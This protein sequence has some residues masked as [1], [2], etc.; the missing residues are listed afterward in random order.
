[1]DV[2]SLLLSEHSEAARRVR[3]ARQ[4]MHAGLEPDPTHVRPLILESWRR[5]RTAGVDPLW[6]SKNAST[7]LPESVLSATGFRETPAD[8][9]LVEAAVPALEMLSDALCDRGYAMMLTDRNRRTAWLSG[10]PFVHEAQWVNHQ[11]G[12]QWDEDRVG[13]DAVALSHVIGKPV[14]VHWYEHYTEGLDPWTGNS[15]PIRDPSTRAVVG[16]INVY[17]YGCI[18]HPQAFELAI[19][20]AGIIERQLALGQQQ[21]RVRL[22]EA[23]QAHVG[24]YPDDPVVCL[25]QEGM[26][27]GLSTSAC[28]PLRLRESDA[29]GKPLLS[30]PGI[31]LHGIAKDFASLSAAQDVDLRLGDQR[32]A[33][34]IRPIHQASD[35]AGFLLRLR[36]SETRRHPGRSESPWRSRHRFQDIVG[37]SDALRATIGQARRVSQRDDT[38]LIVGESGTG[39]ELFAHA[40]H[41]ESA[42]AAGPFV[43]I[44][45]GGM[46]GDLL[47]AE[48]F[49][50]EEGAFTG[51]ARGG[52]TGKIELADR[53]TLFL[54]EVEAMS[55]EL[56]V[57]LLRFLEE[58]YVIRVGAERPRPVDV[59]ILGAT[60]VDLSQL[61]Q[62]GHFRADLYYRLNVCL[63][64]TPPLRERTDDIGPLVA[65]ILQHEQLDKT[66]DPGALA[67]LARHAWPGNI[68]ELRNTLVQAA[69]MT[70]SARITLADLKLE[71]EAPDVTR[72]ISESPLN[73]LRSAE[74]RAIQEVLDRHGGCI[75]TA[76]AE[77]NIHRVT[78]Y[79]KLK[80]HGLNWLPVYR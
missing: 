57:H 80:R 39:K 33:A 40:I 60:N 65:H 11:S 13:T 42:R 5:S 22:F 51:A 16:T 32:I 15:S 78:L 75:S 79:R 77:L 1:M 24:R 55:R 67:A 27:V 38:V 56:Q 47:A 41:A 6:S 26:I 69:L 70:S 62:S 20:A 12:G 9:R 34:E 25:T 46:S 71:G 44:N 52:R 73:I 58:R 10:G 37:S 61:V 64:R 7:Q 48:L 14:Q 23:Y 29:R 36:L 21:R 18:A 49:G 54:D 68:R 3:T 8:P 2:K 45:C 30:L 19:D 66:L 72:Q 4:R 50:Y 74:M 17:A 35:V 53:G 43:P 76:A 59:R 31:Q 63:V 28:P